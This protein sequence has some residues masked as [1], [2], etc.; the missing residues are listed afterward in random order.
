MEF[1]LFLRAILALLFVTGLIGLTSIL[2]KKYGPNKHLNLTKGNKRLTITEI[3]PLDHRNRLMLI[4]RDNT[5]HLI[6]VGPA[7]TTLI[8]SNIPPK[9]KA[10]EEST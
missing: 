6:L 7:E 9:P 1:S 3:T 4:K 5:E 8:E 10:S 2:I